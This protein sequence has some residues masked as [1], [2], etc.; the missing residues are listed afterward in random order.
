MT[1]HGGKGTR[2]QDV[3]R[4]GTSLWPSPNDLDLSPR[5]VRP[6][7]A[8]ALFAFK[9]DVRAD[10]NGFVRVDTLKDG[11]TAKMAISKSDSF[12]TGCF[13]CVSKRKGHKGMLL[14]FS[15]SV[16]FSVFLFLV[17]K[18]LLRRC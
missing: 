18:L 9:Q 12:E 4:L 15:L 3:P 13:G 8:Y 1:T 16:C 2:R 14:Y 17:F 6:A 5:K 11:G 10:S 7:N